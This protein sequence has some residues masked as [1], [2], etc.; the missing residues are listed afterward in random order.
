[1]VAHQVGADPA[2]VVFDAISGAKA[3][4]ADV[5]IIDTA[6]RLHNKQN[7]MDELGKIRA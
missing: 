4:R 6:G 3:R 7:L 5:L 2:A 1:V